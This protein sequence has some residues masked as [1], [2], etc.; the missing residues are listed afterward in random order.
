M[1]QYNPGWNSKVESNRY[2][3][4]VCVCFFS[5]HKK[6]QHMKRDGTPHEEQRKLLRF[7]V[8]RRHTLVRM[9]TYRPSGDARRAEDAGAVPQCPSPNAQKTYPE[10]Y[11]TITTKR[12]ERRTQRLINS[13]PPH[14]ATH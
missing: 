7:A 4:G 14:D 3:W 11:A 5:V 2:L 8:T 12:I 9:K 1:S 6:N 10:E 13:Q